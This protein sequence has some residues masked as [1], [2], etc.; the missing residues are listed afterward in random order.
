MGLAGEKSCTPTRA[1]TA[2]MPTSLAYWERKEPMFFWFVKRDDEKRKRSVHATTTTTAV[3]MQSGI[4][5]PIRS[6][7]PTMLR[8]STRRYRSESNHTVVTGKVCVYSV[9]VPCRTEERSPDAEI[10]R[11]ECPRGLLSTCVFLFFSPFSCV[12]YCSM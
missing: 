9:P 2:P 5:E 1:V 12:E 7:Q 11:V 4:F 10:S 6:G 3:E 8:Y